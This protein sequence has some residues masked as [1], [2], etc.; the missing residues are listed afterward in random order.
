[1]EY[2]T[3]WGKKLREVRVEDSYLSLLTIQKLEKCVSD[4]EILVTG[5]VTGGNTSTF[6]TF[7]NETTKYFYVLSAFMV[8]LQKHFGRWQQFPPCK[9][10]QKEKRIRFATFKKRLFLPWQNL[11]RTHLKWPNN[12]DIKTIYSCWYTR[13][14]S[15]KVI[16]LFKH[17]FFTLLLMKTLTMPFWWLE[18]CV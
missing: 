3:I 12:N 7:V 4:G 17:N 11:G 13:W 10:Q 8:V 16:V 14:L 2:N 1:M 18:E 9:G 15:P 5:M 6:A